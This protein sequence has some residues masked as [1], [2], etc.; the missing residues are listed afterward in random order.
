MGEVKRFWNIGK[1]L[2]IYQHFQRKKWYGFIEELNCYIKKD[3]RGA[4]LIPIKTKNVMFL[5]IGRKDIKEELK[6]FLNDWENLIE[7]FERV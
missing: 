1:E 7:I 3:L 4:I 2:L 6:M 5:Y